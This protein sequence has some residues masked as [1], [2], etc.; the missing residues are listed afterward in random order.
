VKAQIAETDNTISKERDKILE[1]A[2]GALRRGGKWTGTPLS[3]GH[4]QQ[5]KTLS[6]RGIKSG[7][8]E[9]KKSE[10]DATQGFVRDHECKRGKEVAR[11]PAARHPMYGVIDAARERAAVP[12]SPNPN[13]TW[14]SPGAGKRWEE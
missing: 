12:Y 10:V 2:R 8:Y 5:L 9:S 14:R 3:P 13:E 1:L 11:G 7:R 4:R 6:S